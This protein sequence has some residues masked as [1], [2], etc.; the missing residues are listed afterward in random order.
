MFAAP[1][2]GGGFPRHRRSFGKGGRRH[3]R[4]GEDLLRNRG[5]TL[6]QGDRGRRSGKLVAEGDFLLSSR[7]P[8]TAVFHPKCRS[9]EFVLKFSEAGMTS[10]PTPTQR[11]NLADRPHCS[12]LPLRRPKTLPCCAG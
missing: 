9:D 1:K 2:P 6:S 4:P 5:A 12:I 10:L 8:G 7:D 3:D 11:P